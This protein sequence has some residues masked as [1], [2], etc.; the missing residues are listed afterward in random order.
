MTKTVEAFKR[1][2]CW[3]KKTHFSV[4]ALKDKARHIASLLVL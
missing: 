1:T 2:E 4:R 3:H